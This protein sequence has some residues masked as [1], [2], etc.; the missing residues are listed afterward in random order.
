MAC[1][2]TPVNRDVNPRATVAVVG[3]SSALDSASCGQKDRVVPSGRESAILLLFLLLAGCTGEDSKPP[4]G[5]CPVS[6]VDHFRWTLVDEPAGT[7]AGQ[8]PGDLGPCSPEDISTELYG[9]GSFSVSVI[10][11]TCS[12]AALE[13]PL[14]EPVAA[15]EMLQIRIGHYELETATATQG[16]LEID[17]DGSS[18]WTEI[19]PIPIGRTNAALIEDEVPSPVAAPAGAPIRWRVQNHGV[20]SWNLLDVSVQKTCPE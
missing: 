19:V 18:A 10:T 1:I 20:N 17:L 4:P 3:T 2:R 8:D 9:D 7:D 14:L 6:L 15:G 16:L 11:R 12:R 13:Q 5:T